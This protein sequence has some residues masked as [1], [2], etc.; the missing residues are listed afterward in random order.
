MLKFTPLAKDMVQIVGAMPYTVP[1][2]KI[3]VLTGLGV[4]KPN[5]LPAGPAHATFK[6]S[7][8]TRTITRGLPSSWQSSGGACT[9]SSRLAFGGD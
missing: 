2:G 9:P 3:F 1:T 8:A 6:G 5:Q 7:V 4:E